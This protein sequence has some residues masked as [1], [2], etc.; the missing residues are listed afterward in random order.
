MNSPD[1]RIEE[2][3]A[4][5]MNEALPAIIEKAKAEK[6]AAEARAKD[7]PLGEFRDGMYAYVQRLHGLLF[8]FFGRIRPRNCD[9]FQLF[10][11][12]TQSLVSKG[13]LDPDVLE[14][15]E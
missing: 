5:V 11:P 7:L 2:F 12:I 8:W 13:V 15:F 9:C 4:C 3:L 10:R 6:R 14:A 1:G